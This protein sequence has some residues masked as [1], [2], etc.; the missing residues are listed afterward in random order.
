MEQQVRNALSGAFP[1][2]TADLEA[3]QSGRL[4]GIV[5][6]EGFAPYGQVE[7]Q[8]RLRETL[9][10][11]LGDAA[12]KVGVLLTFTPEEMSGT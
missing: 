8:Q 4:S 1:G 6:W 11:A 12:Q 7:R 5:V 2:I 3:M 9:Q 10:R